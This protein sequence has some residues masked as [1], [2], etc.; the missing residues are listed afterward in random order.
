ME[1]NRQDL[2]ELI[3]KVQSYN[4]TC[5]LDMYYPSTI[6]DWLKEN[7]FFDRPFKCNMHEDPSCGDQIYIMP[8]PKP[9]ES[10]IKIIIE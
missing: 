3:E 9:K 7:G 5:E 10:Y 4:P 2:E 6:T 8:A 1:L